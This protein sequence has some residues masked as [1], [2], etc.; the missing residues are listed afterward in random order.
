MAVPAS[1]YVLGALGALFLVKGFWNPTRALVK[2]GSVSSCSGPDSLGVC[3]ATMEVNVEAG[4]AV[5][6]VGTGKIVSVG[7]NW[8]HV[9]LANE[10]VILFYGGVS[11]LVKED[12]HVTR[13]QKI[14]TAIQR[15]EFG[16]WQ[17]VPNAAG[18]VALVP[19]EPASWLAARG[20]RIAEHYEGEADLWCEQR[21]HIIVPKATYSGCKLKNPDA[22]G[23]ALLP[24]SIEQE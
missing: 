13:G 12:N 22:A 10:P 5:Y 1:T 8:V 6:S 2:K 15:I 18:A 16:V 4:K 23:F 14:A 17:L 3:H 24:V 11:P 21:R 19:V 20:Y 7:P 9:E